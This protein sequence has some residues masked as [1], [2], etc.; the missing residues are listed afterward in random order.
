MHQ[1]C[2]P[3]DKYD[4]WNKNLPKSAIQFMVLTMPMDKKYLQ[5][6][7][8]WCVGHKYYGETCNLERFKAS[9]DEE[10]IKKLTQLIG[11]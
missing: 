2:G 3:Q 10:D 4:R 1:W 11:K 8:E 9:Y 6:E 5:S 7:Y